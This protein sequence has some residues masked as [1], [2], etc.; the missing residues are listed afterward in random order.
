MFPYVNNR[1]TDYSCSVHN[2]RSPLKGMEKGRKNIL[3]LEHKRNSYSCFAR[4]QILKQGLYY[5]AMVAGLSPSL[6]IGGCKKQTTNIP[7]NVI[8][9]SIDTLRADHLGCYGYSRPTSPILDRLASQGLLFENVMSTSPWTLPAHGTL[10][11]GLYPSRHGLT[12]YNTRLPAGI[13]TLADILK[14]HGF[15]TAAIVNT[16]VLTA[17]YGLNQGFSDFTYVDE[18]L[19]LREPT[20]VG[21]KAVKWLSK[22]KAEPF[23]LFLHYFDIHS[24]YCSLPYYEKQFVRPYQG[25]ADGT[26]K[27][28]IDFYR[29]QV[30]FDQNDAE[31]L[32]DLYDASIRQMDDGIAHL[33][34]LLD[35]NELL[36]KSLV[37]VTS[38]HGEEFL[39][40]GGVL[41]SRTQYQELIHVPLIVRGPGITHSKRIK[42]PV[43]LVDIMPTILSL[44]AIDK[45]AWLDGLDLCPLWQKSDFKL[46]PRYLFAEGSRIM[47]PDKKIKDIDIK[48]AVRHFRYK[49]HYDKSTKAV[50]LYDL[51]NDPREKIDVAAKHANL[52]GSMLSQ[53]KDFMNIGIK[54]APLPPLSPQ[55]V[56]KLKSLG[57]LG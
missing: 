16:H 24:D 21:A 22:H 40:H 28:L 17:R 34:Q 10:L 48:R 50:Q 18:N 32:I 9:I 7:T 38:D 26:T 29:G 12:A 47:L 15:L 51:W 6:W 14:E 43:S 11:T 1:C 8:L 53:L 13:I 42:H 36:D 33:L 2:Q 49:L 44:L 45:P 52:V 20:R 19:R 54:G 27:Q 46:A 25:F 35:F 57:Y 39:D 31:H 41:H 5:A 4:R 55:D 30:H 3:D 56:Q 37:I 23:F